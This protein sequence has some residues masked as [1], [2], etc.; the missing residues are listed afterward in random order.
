VPFFAYLDHPDRTDPEYSRGVANPT[1]V[2]GQVHNLALRLEQ[3]AFAGVVKVENRQL[4]HRLL[5]TIALR[6]VFL[7]TRFD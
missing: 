1:T 2:Q 5:T 4:A 3:M 6:A 7:P